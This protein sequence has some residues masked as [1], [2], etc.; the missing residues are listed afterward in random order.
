[1]VCGEEHRLTGGWADGRIGAALAVLLHVLASRGVAQIGDTAL[2]L[3]PRPVSV[4][5]QPG[6]FTLAAT[7]V[8]ATDRATRDLGHWLAGEL[9]KGSGFRLSVQSLAANATSRITIRLDTSLRRLGPEGYRLDVAPSRVTV[10]A[11]EPAGAFYGLQTLRQ[12]FPPDLFRS[13]PL[14][15]AAWTAPAVTIEDRPRF[16][17]RGAHLDVGRHFFP[18]WFVKRYIDLIAQYKLNVFHWHLTEDQGWR[19]EITKY[20]RLT[21]VGAYRRETMVAQN[22]DPY[23]GDGTPYGGFYTQDDIREVVAYAAARHVTVVP[24]IEMPGHSLAALAAYPE[25]ACTPGPFEVGTRWGVFEDVYCPTERTFTFLE[26]VLTE[27]LAVF[28]SRYIHIGGDEVPK[29]RWQESPAAQEVRRREGLANEH[30]LQSFF[31]RRIERFLLSRDRRLIGWDEI[32]EGGLA[33][34]ATVMSWRGTEGGIAAARQGH[35]VVM[36]PYSH[37]Y[38]DYYQGNPA[39]EPPANGGLIPLEKVYAFEPVPDSLT[40]AEARHVL[41]AQAN[42]WTEYMKTPATVEYM[43]FPRLLAL[44]EV[45]WSARSARNWGDFAQRL[46]A[47]LAVLDRLD[48]NF[49]VPGVLGLEEDRLSLG[50]SVTVTLA[51][52][53]PGGEIRYTTDGADPLT[54]GVS[55]R[56]PVRMRVTDAGALVRARAFLPGGRFSPAA[57]A[58]FAKT[59]LRPAETMAEARLEPGLATAYWESNL[60]T[61]R[62]LNDTLAPDR[63]GQADS[64]GF[65][66]YQRAERFALRFVGYLKVPADGIYRFTLTSDDG[67]TLTV[68]NR[69]VVENDGLHGPVEKSGLVALRAG[70]QPVMLDYFQAGG[71]RTLRLAIQREGDPEPLRPAWFRSR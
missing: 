9:G 32:L 46:P 13:A 44:A 55:Y 25:L 56:G 58:R 70:L 47:Q 7:T 23:V 62:Q 20:P 15:G 22:F 68:G 24:E 60:R 57:A 39:F 30:E 52:L 16:T 14:P 63:E 37:V 71:A 59:S 35:D 48:V 45:V 18:V 11:L 17:W 43:A 67:S 50:D 27:V 61:V 28:P 5:R 34:Q 38:F 49:R 53:V 69:T 21:Q 40:E 66:G 33:P 51:P 36:A 6:S 12:L 31:I 29:R 8:I 65:P 1:V 42:V 41:G 10:R 3:I 19:I 2:A 54:G 4:T 26:D 64:I